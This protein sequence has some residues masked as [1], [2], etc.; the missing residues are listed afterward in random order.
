MEALEIFLY[1]AIL[2][3]IRLV[4]ALFS[5]LRFIFLTFHFCLASIRGVAK[6]V[7]SVF[8]V[9][10]KGIGTIVKKLG[11]GF[12]HTFLRRKRTSQK[13]TTRSVVTKQQYQSGLKT[14]VRYFFYGTLFSLIFFFLPISIYLFLQELPNP[15]ALETRQIP[16]TTKIYDRNGVLL[17]QIYGPQDRTLVQLSE[18]PDSMKKATI[19]IEDK[20]FY[21]HPGFDFQ[22]I[23]RAIR[24]DISGR[25][26][27][28]A[29]TITQQLVRS[30]FLTNDPDVI[31]KIKEI[32]I[33]FWTERV[34][35]K[36]QILEM[37]FNQV[38][39]GGTAWGVEA[40]ADVY[41]G[42]HVKDL[43]LAQSAFLA[44]ITT[45]P[46]LYSP[47]G[48]EP[49]RWKIRQ[50]EVLNQMVRLGFINKKQ[51][52]EALAETLIFR[53]R[54]IAINAPHF[55]NYVKDYLAQKYGLAMLERG[56]LTIKTSLDMTTQKQAE[57]I[58]AE[59]VANDAY[60]NLTNG[61][62]LVTKP[63]NGDILAMVGSHDFNDP[64]GGNVNVTTRTRQPGSS[65]KPVT[66]AAALVKGVTAATLLDDSPVTYSIPGGYPYS[67]VNYDGRSHGRVPLRIAL[68]NSFNI[69]AVRLLN[70]I[71]IPSMVSLAKV[72]GIT[73]W[74][75]P[76]EYGLSLTLG[77]AE[78]KMT[79]MATVYGT[80]ANG[81]ERVDINPILKITDYKGNI[82]EEK[83][84]P[85]RTRVLPKTV[86]FIMSN[87]LA[88]PQARLIEFGSNT[89]LIIPGHTV[90]V[91]TGTTDNKRDNWTIG[92]TNNYLT[93]VWVGNNDNSPM[94][95]SLASGITGAAP[96]WNRMMT[97]LLSKDPES[98][99][100]MPEDIVVRSCY[101]KTEY[102]VR[103]TEQT[104]SCQGYSTPTSPPDQNA[105]PTPQIFRRDRRF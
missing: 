97:A 67:P 4:D 22:A 46:T 71:G 79:D 29:S 93:A 83:T 69:T 68:G 28:G 41:F 95:Q 94:S 91:K 18:I 90:S 56:G 17:T 88:D 102:F 10:F 11:R 58:V 33:A 61:A 40:A 14:G 32:I 15:K 42:K 103:G 23:L 12:R 99:P 25:S 39:Y 78:V 105:Q 63:A 37:Y 5:L 38:P 82:L 50:K 43:N 44:G 65:I 70:Q 21:T 24:E 101:G 104:V 16:Q 34:Y 96:I 57:Q 64:N 60:L 19:A 100:S 3:L 27:Q 47:Y 75:S 66:Y 59:E 86:A 76:D 85:R 7:V 36:D 80:F 9:F 30:S 72:M 53:D 2:L 52:E 31:R 45:A 84:I 51:Q 55:V 26:F 62:M 92:Y 49:D 1:Y 54:S 6:G 81:G 8:H 48:Q 13:K 77:A 87:I 35:S 73:T 89:P 98:P 74:G 20:N